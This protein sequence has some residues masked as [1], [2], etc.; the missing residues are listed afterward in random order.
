MECS[1]GQVRDGVD[2]GA[3]GTACGP[4]ESAELWVGK[5]A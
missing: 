2:S 4:I 1:T 3:R 5:E